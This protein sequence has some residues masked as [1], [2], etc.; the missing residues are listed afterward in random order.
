M[1]VDVLEREVILVGVVESSNL[2]VVAAV[3]V[4]A[5]VC[6]YELWKILDFL[7]QNLYFYY[8]YY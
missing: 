2:G 5:V 6:T 4:V 7:F 1:F 8:Y 3:V